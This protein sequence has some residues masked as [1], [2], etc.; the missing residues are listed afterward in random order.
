MDNKLV[1][2][3]LLG[4]EGYG[5]KKINDL[6][7]RINVTTIDKPVDFVDKIRSSGI[8]IKVPEVEDLESSFD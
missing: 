1:C 6:L 5:P 7:R 8:K 2:L 3:T 4:I